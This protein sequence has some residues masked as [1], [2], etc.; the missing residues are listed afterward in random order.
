MVRTVTTL[1]WLQ[2]HLLTCLMPSLTGAGA[3][4]EAMR[5]QRL[6]AEAS[7]RLRWRTESYVL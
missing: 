4:A 1:S 7:L 3:I 5:R 2:V 6:Y